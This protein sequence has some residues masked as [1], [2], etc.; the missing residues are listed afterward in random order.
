MQNKENQGRKVV[1]PVLNRV[2]KWGI[3]VLN[4]V[5]VC[6]PRRHTSPQSFLECPH[7]GEYTSVMPADTWVSPFGVRFTKVW[8]KSFSV[9]RHKRQSAK[10]SARPLIQTSAGPTLRVFKHLRT[11]TRRRNG[12]RLPLVKRNYGKQ[13]IFNNFFMQCIKSSTSSPGIFPKKNVYLT[14]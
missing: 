10:P 13:R 2:A 6:R 4:R 9:D 12:F 8:L 14:F 3:F 7:P 5:E 1:S 11:N